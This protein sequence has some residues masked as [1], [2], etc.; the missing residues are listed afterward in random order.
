MTIQT[1]GAHKRRT[2]SLPFGGRATSDIRARQECRAELS[3]FELRRAV[4]AM[5]D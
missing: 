3:P 2:L 4:A 5:V 1:V